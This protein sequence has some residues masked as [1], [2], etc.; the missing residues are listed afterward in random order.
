MT[1]APLTYTAVGGTRE[2]GFAPPGFAYLDR[3]AV[4]G[5]GEETF[6]RARELILHWEVQRRSGMRVAAR[7]DGSIAVGDVV[8]LG[9]PFGPLHVSAPARVVYV[10]DELRKAGF[11]YGTLRGHPERGEELFQVE[12]DDAGAVWMRVRAFS[13]PSGRIWWLGYPIIRLTQEFYTR[14]YLRALA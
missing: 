7:G 4:I 8:R 14:R 9:I 12:L 6:T 1:D 5:S 13:R 2:P 11:A 3:A 10:V